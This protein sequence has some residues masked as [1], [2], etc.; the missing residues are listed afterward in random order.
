MRKIYVNG[1]HEY[2]YK[3]TVDEFNAVSVDVHELYIS[4]NEEWSKSYRG[5]LA[6]RLIDTG[7]GITFATPKNEI[8]Y[9]DAQQLRILLGI[10]MKDDCEQLQI[11]IDI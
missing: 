2:D 3:K 4:N 10:I 11:R 1:V 8:D 9:S 5:L 6:L 7:D